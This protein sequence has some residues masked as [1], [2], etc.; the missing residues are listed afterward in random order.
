MLA[1]IEQIH[2]E[3]DHTNLFDCAVYACLLVVFWATA[4]L[5]EFVLTT[6]GAFNPALHVKRSDLSLQRNRNGFEVS[7]PHTH[8]NNT[9]NI[10][11][12]IV[13]CHLPHIKVKSAAE[14]GEDVFRAA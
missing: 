9:H 6:L 13:N 8:S 12:Q 10:Y 7:T 2:G 4:W 5:G 3:L 1:L 11:Y 14:G